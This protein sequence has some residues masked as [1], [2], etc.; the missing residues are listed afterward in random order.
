[1]AF[2]VKCP[3]R[4]G[5]RKPVRKGHGE[6]K[7]VRKSRLLVLALAFVMIF[8]LALV[9]CDNNGDNGNG[10]VA[11]DAT[12]GGV[13][14]MHLGNPVGID[15]YNGF[16]TAGIQVI[17]ALFNPLV[18]G[19]VLDPSNLVPAAA[20]SWEINDENTVFTFNLDPDA[21]F[22]NDTPVTANDFVYAFNRI[23]DPY[24]VNTLTGDPDAGFLHAQLGAIV[25]YEEF[26]DGDTD[27]MEGLVAL[28]DHTLEITLSDPFADFIFNVTH[29]SFVPV[30]QDLIE[31][32]V[33]Y[34]GDYVP[35]GL[36]PIGNGP[37]RMV[38]P[39]VEGQSITTERNPYYSGEAAYLDGVEFRLFADVDTAFMSFQAGDLDY[40][41][42]A[43]G[44]LQSVK[45]EFG[46]ASNNGFTANPGEQVLFGAE[47]ATYFMNF[48]TYEGPMANPDLRRAVTLAI[49]RDAINEVVWEGSYVIATDILPPGVPA[50]E[51]GSWEDA[52][53]DREAARQALADAGYPEGEGL[54]P[55]RISYNVEGIHAPVVEL[56]TADLAAIGIDTTVESLDWTTFNNQVHDKNYDIARRGWMSSY[57]STH[58]WLF[59]LFG[60]ESGN[61]DTFF[62]NAEV[63]EL[64]ASA[65]AIADPAERAAEYAR[66]NEIIQSYNPVAPIAYFANRSVVSDRMHNVNI[67]PLSLMDFKSIWIPTDSQ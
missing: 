37:F 35:F 13:F 66:A 5:K 58:Y 34:D 39:W 52:R 59:E 53:F 10:V 50:H 54:D 40:S 11:S 45:D 3:T 57:P 30:P 15:P 46:L 28:D 61:N 49:N 27:G 17:N 43:Q 25:G 36:M 2:V 22:A 14:R 8:A 48:N 18:K 4:A 60:S 44:H 42:V 26:R 6:E 64:L 55:I 67:G 12:P 51:L 23:V 56:I 41:E 19:D 24:A 63:D 32:G 62:S 1:M 20:L 33:P 7:I 65:A 31:N 21:R 47:M 29:P 16:E 38:E 9:G